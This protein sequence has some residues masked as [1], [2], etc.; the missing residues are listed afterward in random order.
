[1][2][3]FPL[4]FTCRFSSL[5]IEN[6]TIYNMGRAMET[7]VNQ[8]GI[9]MDALRSSRIPFAGGQ[10]AGDS[11]SALAKDREIIGSQAPVI[12]SDASQSVGQG[13][14]WQFPS[15]KLLQMNSND[16]FEYLN[17]IS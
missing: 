1:M 10:Q 2:V 12:A 16:L 11:S 6:V 3:G 14:L 13:G 4:I 8:H 17:L 7:V 9:D 5:L 15:S